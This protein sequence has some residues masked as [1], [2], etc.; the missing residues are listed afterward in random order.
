[1]FKFNAT[2]VIK[3]LNRMDRKQAYTWGAVGVGVLVALL[4]LASFLGG[5]EEESFDG[6]Q[7][8]GYDLANSPFITD[9]AE[10]FLLASKY[11]DMKDNNANT[12]YSPMEKEERQEEDAAQ[13]AEEDSS[14]SDY[15]S[16]NSSSGYSSRGYSGR[17]GGSRTPTQVG[18]LGGAS[19]SHAGGTGLSS[20][21]GGPRVDTTPYQQN[22]LQSAKI[23]T[24]GANAGNGRRSLSQ[25]ASATQAGA[26]LKDNKAVNQ[27]RSLQGG[28]V[29][30]AGGFKEDGTVDMSKVSTDMLDTNAPQASGDLDNIDKAV[31]DAG[32]KAKDKNDDN[33]D[34]DK[35]KWGDMFRDILGT[36]AKETFSAWLKGDTKWQQD[37]S[38]QKILTGQIEDIQQK[39]KSGGPDAKGIPQ[40]VA[41]QLNSWGIPGPANSQHCP[42]CD[43]TWRANDHTDILEGSDPSALALTAAQ[44]LLGNK[45]K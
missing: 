10:E 8:R 23:A 25:F 19:M 33:K 27:K 16:G 21:Y 1:M 35:D 15:S 18:Q 36:V 9:E 11:P 44:N 40:G 42:T 30:G 22:K 37:K 2:N 12:L 38:Q 32:Q 20:T 14:S 34:E 13:E 41:D 7:A 26:R 17:G 28:E 39:Y 5:A 29:A 45:K 24:V 3:K 6:F 43:G 31:A 4:L